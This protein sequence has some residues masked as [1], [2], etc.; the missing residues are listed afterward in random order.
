MLFTFGG[1]VHYWIKLTKEL[2]NRMKEITAYVQKEKL[3]MPTVID[4]ALKY[5]EDEHK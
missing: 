2:K 5:W 1:Q 3:D 4:Q